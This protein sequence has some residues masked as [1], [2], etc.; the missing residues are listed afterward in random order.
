MFLGRL[1]SLNALEQTRPSPNW[2]RWIGGDLPSA[3]SIGRIACGLDHDDLRAVNHYLYSRLKR[4]KA[5][6]APWHGLIALAVDGHE[7]HSTY[8]RHCDG[9]LELGILRT[10]LTNV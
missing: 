3:D 7:S 6:A 8:R 10:D 2:L 4:I 1:G 9:C 5:L